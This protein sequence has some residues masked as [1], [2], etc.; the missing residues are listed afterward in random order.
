MLRSQFHFCKTSCLI[1]IE[2]NKENIV[3][4]RDAFFNVW[5]SIGMIKI[6]FQVFFILKN[7]YKGFIK[8]LPS[9]VCYIL[10]VC[11]TCFSNGYVHTVR[12]ILPAAL[13][14]KLISS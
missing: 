11:Y 6:N 5:N 4:L 3:R 14:E 13:L 9:Y 10:R 2:S 12:L 7:G 1:R 8:G